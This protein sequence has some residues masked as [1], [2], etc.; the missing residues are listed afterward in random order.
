[1]KPGKKPS[2]AQAAQQA[3]A[4][5]RLD[6]IKRKANIA[7]ECL[8]W[9]QVHAAGMSIDNLLAYPSHAKRMCARVGKEFNLSGER[10]EQ[11]IC[12]ALLW[13]RKRKKKKS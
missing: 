2:P 3:R 13:H 4:T 1:M 6:A 11:E 7:S 5:R 10:G 8:G 12:H 9:M